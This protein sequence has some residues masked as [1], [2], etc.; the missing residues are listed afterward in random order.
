MR[1]R[2]SRDYRFEAAH[3]LPKV[4]EGHKCAR[5]HGHSYL[6]V[7]TIEGEIDPE[8]GWVMDFAAIDEHVM[9]LIRALDHQVL[10]EVDG[11]AN[12]TS[13]LL[14][15]WLWDRVRPSLP[16]LVEIQVAETVSSRCVYRG[17][18]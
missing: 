4:P 5:M 13:E 2:L 18:S 7:V 8:L 1:T 10:N 16:V 11:L 9:P 12:P 17:P 3:F 6:V 15:V 14:A